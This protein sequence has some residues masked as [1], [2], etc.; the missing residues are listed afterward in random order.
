VRALILKAQMLY[1]RD[2]VTRL[3]RIGKPRLLILTGFF[4]NDDKKGVDLLVVGKLNRNRFLRVIA[5]L[6]RDLG[7]EINYTHLSTNEF[8]YRRD[9]TDVFLYDILDG[10]KLVVIDEYNIN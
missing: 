7:R 9:I 6:E 8:R 1:E 10:R 5:D 2:F 4:V 3:Q